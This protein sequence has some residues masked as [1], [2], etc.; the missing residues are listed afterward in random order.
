MNDQTPQ[1]LNSKMDAWLTTLIWCA[2]MGSALI[3]RPLLPI[4]ETRYITVAWEMWSS[5][6]FWVPTL[7]G[8]VYSHKPPFMFWFMDLGW[9]IFGVS[10]IWARLVAP[11]FGLGA[12]FVTAKLA[13]ELWPD[14]D[15]SVQNARA[16]M[17]P[18]M[19]VTGI[20]WTVFSTMT[21]FDMIVTFAAVVALL[22]YVKAYKGFASGKGFWKGIL[23]AGFGIGIGGLAKGP[24]I[25][26]HILPVALA[27]PLWGPYLSCGRPD[28]SWRKWYL[29][30]FV[31]VIVGLAMTL[32]WAIP[33]AIIGGAEYRD[34]IFIKQ[35]TDR[36]VKSF[37]HRRPF[38]WF[39]AVMPVLLLPWTLWPRLWKGIGFVQAWKEQRGL[40]SSLHDG[41]VRF[42]LI[43]VGAS[44]VI[45]SAISGKQPHYLL[46]VFPALAIFVAYTLTR[47]D[48]TDNDFGHRVPV[49]VMGGLALILCVGLFAKDAIEPM[50]KKPLP[51]WA[52]LAEPLWLLPVILLAGVLA[53]RKAQGPS[54]EVR[55]IAITV[56]SVIVSLYMSAAPA[57][58]VAY[59]LEPAARQVKAFQDEGRPVAYIG[60][61][62]GEFQF[63]GRLT[64]PLE[65]MQSL[66]DGGLAWAKSHATGVVIATMRKSNVPAA[67]TPISVQPYRGKVLVMWNAADF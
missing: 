23:I 9:S 6:D 18:M 4:D 2:L 12:L 29:G 40:R 16:W 59:N 39:A 58:D 33:A 14:V 62:H 35:S 63:L 47:K 19:M 41:G 28:L 24:A 51:E 66:Q 65:A 56:T 43:C 38:Y 53:F 67:P 25:L 37:A 32:A 11:T 5:G 26:V 7:N 61:Y 52:S 27:A 36:M 20:Y 34:A 10:E 45:F 31:S 21:M 1:S 64:Q 15:A 50:L 22:G 60:K 17:A 44:F 49:L 57:L 48:A 30:V 54:S 3:L 55:M 42:L 13:R 8:E 46:P